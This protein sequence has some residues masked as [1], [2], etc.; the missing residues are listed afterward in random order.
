MD[1]LKE[2][3]KAEDEALKIEKEYKDKIDSLFSSVDK[4]IEKLKKE[5]KEDEEQKLEAF[6]TQL[7]SQFD[8]EKSKII[9]NSGL[10]RKKIEQKALK[11]KEK[12]IKELLKKLV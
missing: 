8:E 5:L 6:Q 7:N 10:E 2:V 12:V 9:K 11:N 3:K 1:V 4:K